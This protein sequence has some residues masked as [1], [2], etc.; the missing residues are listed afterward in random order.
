MR[1]SEIHAAIEAGRGPALPEDRAF[2][3]LVAIDH[4]ALI[5]GLPVSAL[6]FAAPRFGAKYI[7][8]LP[9]LRGSW[10]GRAQYL[11]WRNLILSAQLLF[12]PGD[13]DADPWASLARAERL[14]RENER[15]AFHGLHTLLPPGTHP[16]EVTDALLGKVH[17]AI[18][19]EMEPRLRAGL[20]SFRQLFRNGLAL[21]TGLLPD[22]CPSPLPGSRSHRLFASMSPEIETWRNGLSDPNI[23][24]ALDY[25]SRLAIA[26][27]RLNGET[28]TLDDL[29]V[30]LCDLPSPETVNVP[31][32][33]K[34][35]LYQYEKHLLRGLGGPDPRKSPAEQAW[36]DLWTAART[37]G[38]ETSCL[39]AVSKP[40]A[41]RGLFPGEVS[42][43]VALEILASHHQS[44]R[45]PCRRGCEQLDALRG[46][47]SPDLLPPSPLGIRLHT[48]RPPRAPKPVLPPDPNKIA[49]A[50]LYARLR[51]RGWTHKQTSALSYVRAR[52]STAG[53]APDAL[54]Q[55]FID[56][57]ERDT[58]SVGD[59][60]RLRAAVSCISTLSS[61]PE[62]AH[63]PDLKPIPYVLFTHGGPTERAGAELEE[64][65]DF[66]NAAAPTRCAFRMAVGVLTDAMG[67]PE[68][69]LKKLLESDMSGYDL[70]PH[71]PR[72]KTHAS[73]IQSLRAFLELPWTPAWRELQEVVTGTGLT[74][75]D[76]P[77]PK[78]LAWNPGTDPGDLTLDWAQKLDQELRS[79]LKNPPDG[80]ADL[81][82]KL[83]RHL[84]AFDALHEIP[85]V[86]GSGLLPPRI[87]QIRD[88]VK[89]LRQDADAAALPDVVEMIRHT[90][91]QKSGGSKDYR[92]FVASPG[93]IGER[94]Y[95]ERPRR[96]FTADRATYMLALHQRV[97][98]GD[99]LLSI[100]GA[101]GIV[102]LVPEGVP[103]EE[104]AAIWTVGQSL[105]ILRP[106][107]SAGMDSI[108][109]YEYL[110][111]ETVQELI[112]S[113][114][115]ASAI[116]ILT[117]K[118]LHTFP[119]SIPSKQVMEDMRASFTARQALFDEAADLRRRIATQRA[120]LWP[121]T[122]LARTE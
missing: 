78:V 121:H 61:D 50:D 100:K 42:E 34:T 62:F 95:L 63:L 13:V 72:R 20:N 1:L 88:R 67:R 29:R 74:A 22:V 10:G 39:W 77:A 113:L 43:T 120:E 15:A 58:T 73:K 70:G 117:I 118:D 75:Q 36:A 111:N 99:V 68:I 90:K 55:D 66:M 47:V 24:R 3:T 14:W 53:I 91:L 110:T 59:R 12:A 31:S 81:A 85:A 5:E 92:I 101:C 26:A 94:G 114:A 32:V 23:K 69:S 51:A 103:R 4:L 7:Y 52:A 21:R 9:D 98:P 54:S 105:V 116:P 89:T 76:N 106:K 45:S 8:Q 79:T 115:S 30:A 25:L 104:D 2:A 48:P 102:G 82:R 38:C 33:A 40:A 49:W 27:G 93:D 60:D 97:Q 41:A 65:M 96:S 109:L 28:D 86:A 83:A 16:R 37:A 35:T 19:A 87:G 11:T 44:S 17:D 64:L 6:D 57:L 84:A 46:K 18:P 56:T 112:Q 71:E 107:K 122:R 80:R 119:V 108:S